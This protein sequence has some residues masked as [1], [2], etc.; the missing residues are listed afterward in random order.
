MLK[1]F[2]IL[3]LVVTVIAAFSLVGCKSMFK[4]DEPQ[5]KIMVTAIVKYNQNEVVLPSGREHSEPVR[6]YP[7]WEGY[8]DRTMEKDGAPGWFICQASDIE[9]PDEYTPNLQYGY[10]KFRF[11]ISEP[12]ISIPD[13]A[14]FNDQKVVVVEKEASS[15]Y[16][17]IWI[18]RQGAYRT[19]TPTG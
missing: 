6:V 12:G 19:T 14:Y 16:F 15:Y 11:R 7:S 18:N 17:V 8:R 10:A 3:Q 4:P 9:A 1:K 5:P 13:G 2:F